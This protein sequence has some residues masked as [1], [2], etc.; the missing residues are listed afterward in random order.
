MWD[1]GCGMW[2]MCRD[3]HVSLCR[4]SCAIGERAAVLSSGRGLTMTMSFARP[5]LVPWM[6]AATRRRC[7]VA[8]ASASID[9]VSYPAAPHACQCP[10]RHP[11]RPS[12]RTQGQS[13]SCMLSLRAV[14]ERSATTATAT[15]AALPP[16]ARQAHSPGPHSSVRRRCV[17][18]STTS[19]G[20]SYGSRARGLAVA[21]GVCV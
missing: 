9:V 13:S 1:V 18:A 8:R 20:V 4:V 10:F 3:V 7:S 5:A 17:A 15:A 19:T 16:N 11:T 6:A 2:E 21:R 12:S 14:G